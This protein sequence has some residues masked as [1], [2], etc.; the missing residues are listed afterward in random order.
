MKL[1]QFLN[2]IGKD[3][4]SRKASKNIIALVGIKGLDTLIYF[5]LVPL[6]LGYLNAYEYGIWLTLSS[7]LSWINSFDIG[8]GNG[9]RNKLAES[10][11]VKDLDKAKSYVSTTF[12]L[13]IAIVVLILF[14]CC[15][16]FPLINW[17]ELL[18]IKDGTI[19]NIQSIIIFSIVFFCI[20]FVMKMVGNVYQALQ[21]PAVNNVISLSGH[22]LSSILIWILTK[23][24]FVD[25]LFWVAITYSAS[26]TIVYLIA[27]PVTFKVLYK[28]LCPS[29]SY[30][31]R[32]YIK[33]LLSLSFLFFVLQIAGIILFA[34]SN[35]IISNMF[36]PEQVTP[37]NIA[38][39]YF[40]ILPLMINIIIAPMWSATTEA[41]AKGEFDWIRKTILK[42]V[43][44]LILSGVLLLTMVLFSNVAY[45]LWVGNEI[46]IPIT[47]SASLAIYMF[48]YVW[49][50]SLSFYL[51][52][53]GK[54]R[55]QTY[56]TL[57][58]AILFY[59]ICRLLGVHYGVL[60]VS[61]TMIITAIPGAILNTIQLKKIL[62]NSAKGLWN[63]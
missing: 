40:S 26:P 12:F 22:V 28:Y 7:I 17:N 55:L 20:N 31:K 29:L 59:P 9:L 33:N 43:K 23:T 18:G 63:K 39:R 27:Y 3:E 14:V 30:F 41:Y 5:V 37:Y 21:L 47:L 54:L 25:N 4:R 42:V 11:A 53:I 61:L 24:V 15:C 45:R 32:E 1:N 57:I 19:P 16:I 58:M 62:T 13:L 50:L 51:N 10:L 34:A 44:C 56:N 49:S 48:I 52:G 35:L 8:L 36:G 60:G 46:E 6:T 38:Y 2:L